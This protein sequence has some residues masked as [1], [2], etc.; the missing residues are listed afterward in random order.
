MENNLDNQFNTPEEEP[1]ASM[2]K[3]P[4]CAEEIK[5]DAI[6][7]RYCLS[8]LRTNTEVYSPPEK[9]IEK[10]Q[11]GCGSAIL[12]F[13]L[14]IIGIIVGIAWLTSED[15]RERAWP[16]I[17]VSILGIILWMIII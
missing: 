8:D 3:C 16:M 14:P 11:F 5:E 6:K 12:A 9:V 15:D 7:C 4:Y 17:A 10:N 13:L 1:K 2:K